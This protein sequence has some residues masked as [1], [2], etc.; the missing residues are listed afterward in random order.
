MQPMTFLNSH[1]L[2]GHDILVGYIDDTIKAT[3]ETI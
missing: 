3:K 2:V 1:D